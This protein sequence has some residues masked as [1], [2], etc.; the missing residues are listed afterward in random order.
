MG[1][2]V[3]NAGLTEY[4][5]LDK[6]EKDDIRASITS[7]ADVNAIVGQITLAPSLHEFVRRASPALCDG[8]FKVKSFRGKSLVWNQLINRVD[9][10]YYNN[11][12]I[13]TVASGV[14]TATGTANGN[15]LA[16]IY[17]SRISTPLVNGHKYLVHG[18]DSPSNTKIVDSY[19]GYFFDSGNGVVFT[20][21]DGKVVNYALRVDDGAS[22]VNVRFSPIFIDLTQMFGAGN[23]PTTYEEFLSRKPIVE[24]EFAYNEG[25]IVN[26]SVKAIEVTGRNLWDEEWDVGGMSGSTGNDLETTNSIRSKNYIPVIGGKAY[27]I[28]T[29]LMFGYGFHQYDASYQWLG[30]TY[31]TQGTITLDE[32]CSYVRFGCAPDYGTTYNHDICINLSDPAFNGQYVP[33]VAPTTIDLS[34]VK[35]IKDGDGNI[36]FPDGLR[37]VGN[38]YDEAGQ[39]RA[40]KRFGAVDL[41]SLTWERAICE[42]VSRNYFR[43]TPPVDCKLPATND[44]IGNLTSPIFTPI[45][46]Y[47]AYYGYEG[48]GLWPSSEYLVVCSSAYS[49]MTPEQFKVAMQGVKLIY[50]L[51]TPIKVEYAE[52]KMFFPAS[53]GVEEYIVAE[54]DTTPVSM[55]AGYPL[56]LRS[57]FTSAQSE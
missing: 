11:G 46:G 27:Y 5:R 44:E 34:W 38:V 55:E 20:Y 22:V 50:E 14:V 19:S 25:E 40:V 29:P 51:A 9:R 6:I 36:L 45:L 2:F 16:N 28:V 13:F 18:V 42:G 30:C 8:M 52:R 26:N 49:D 32:N 43:T 31:P 10:Q 53:L 12:V 33:Y 17:D 3:T 21:T 4:R 24:D 35:N 1:K 23:E 47:L 7:L 56:N 15:A 39:T 41:G 54:G 48:V 57:L 37:G